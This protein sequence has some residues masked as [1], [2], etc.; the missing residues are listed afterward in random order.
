M[1]RLVQALVGEQVPVLV[2]VQRLLELAEPDVGLH[3]LR[4][5]GIGVRVVVLFMVGPDVALQPLRQTR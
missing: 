2:C 5:D 3:G 4:V 1:R